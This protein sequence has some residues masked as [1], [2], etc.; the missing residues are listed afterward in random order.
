MMDTRST[1]TRWTIGGGGGATTTRWTG[2]TWGGGGANTAI[3]CGF[4][5]DCPSIAAIGTNFRGG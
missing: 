1:A 3:G 4:V 2:K 5:W